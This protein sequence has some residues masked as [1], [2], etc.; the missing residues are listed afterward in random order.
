MPPG[1]DKAR[2]APYPVKSC[3]VAGAHCPPPVTCCSKTSPGEL[4]HDCREFLPAKC[5]PLPAINCSANVPPSGWAVY[6]WKPSPAAFRTSPKTQMPVSPCRAGKLSKSMLQQF[7]QPHCEAH[8]LETI[9]RPLTLK[10]VP[11]R[12][13]LP[14]FDAPAC[15][16]I[17]DVPQYMTCRGLGS[18]KL[19]GRVD[20]KYTYPGMLY[21]RYHYFILYRK[22]SNRFYTLLLVKPLCL[23]CNQCMQKPAYVAYNAIHVRSLN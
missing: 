12:P 10:Y 15:N 13:P 1:A 3:P 2:C 22:T 18:N 21:V 11:E 23:S 14:P 19:I 17:P 16:P 8:S 7:K 6:G 20:F 9:R 5:P 4:S